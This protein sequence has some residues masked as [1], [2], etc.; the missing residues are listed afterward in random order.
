MVNDMLPEPMNTTKKDFMRIIGC[1]SPRHVDGIMC[2]KQ[3]T[4][5]TDLL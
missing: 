5:F 1:V 2:C 4:I 3:S